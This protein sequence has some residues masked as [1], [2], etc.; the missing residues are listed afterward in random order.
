MKKLLKK[1]LEEIKSEIAADCECGPCKLHREMAEKIE[2]ELSKFDS[3]D[4]F[5]ID[6]M[7]QNLK[8]ERLK[9][10][11][12]TNTHDLDSNIMLLEKILASF[13]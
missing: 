8:K 13:S 9:A 6:Q 12:R 5:L 7:F 3:S 4:I 1:L 2:K 10:N 11:D